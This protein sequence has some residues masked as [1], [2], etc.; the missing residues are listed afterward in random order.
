MSNSNKTL[1]IVLGILLA[2]VIGVNIWLLV[3][4]FNKKKVIEETQQELSETEA[5]RVELD[6]KYNTAMAQLD[7]LKDE[8][9]ELYDRIE[10]QKEAL[11]KEKSKINR[12]ISRGDLSAQELADAQQMISG[13]Q[14][15]ISGYV[16]EIDQLKAQ[17]STL[18]AETVTLKEEK[19]GLET[20]IETKEEEKAVLSREKE[21]LESEKKV[22]SSKV[23]IGQ[24][25]KANYITAKAFKLKGGT[26][27]KEVKKAK[28]ADRLKVCFQVIENKITPTGE[29]TLHMR[30]I[31]PRG[32]TIAVDSQGSGSF[33]NEDSG[34]T[35]RY[36]KAKT[37]N[38]VNMAEDLCLNWD[39][40]DVDL[41]AGVYNV[42]V[43][44]K[45]YLAGKN[46]FELK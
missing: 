36:T 4:K 41:T 29:N 37:I 18:T 44:N 11:R 38:Y 13:F 45:G 22:L 10:E 35:I 24:L 9:D 34:E 43:Y 16:A 2:L 17:N 1:P 25:L 12:L 8:N 23:A 26:V 33:M 21:D 19:A 20:V 28:A 3:D 42:E 15:Q 6:E 5:L 31:N 7:E 14:A 40:G 32:E 46:T 39:I 27:E 30:I